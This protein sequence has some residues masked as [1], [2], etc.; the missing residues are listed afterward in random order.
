MH[1][2][3]SRV[4]KLW[5]VA[6]CVLAVSACDPADLVKRKVP[7]LVRDALTFGMQPGGGA[8]GADAEKP[9]LA[10]VSPKEN[11]AYAPGQEILFK[12]SGKLTGGKNPQQ[13]ELSWNLTPVSGEGRPQ[14]WQG[15]NTK[16][17]KLPVGRYKVE[18]TAK[19]E[20][21]PQKYGQQPTNQEL[22]ITASFA[23]AY[24][25]KG[26]VGLGA[27]GLDQAEVQ[28]VDMEKSTVAS[29]ATSGKNG[30]FELHF[31]SHGSFKIEPRKDGYSFSPIYRRVKF[32]GE[33]L[34]LQFTAAKAAFRNMRITVAKDSDEKPASL[35]PNDEAYL[36]LEVVSEVPVVSLEASLLN[37][38][39]EGE[40]TVIG[41][42]TDLNPTPSAADPNA[43]KCV[44]IKI[45]ISWKQHHLKE[46]LRLRVTAQDQA[47]GH[48]AAEAPD[49]VVVD[50]GVCMTAKTA[51]ALEL[52][53]K[54]NLE[55]ALSEFSGSL[56]LE[57]NLF[58]TDE[59]QSAAAKSSLNAGLVA[60]ELV[61][62]SP[63]DNPKVPGYVGKALNLF[64]DVVKL[65]PRDA[66]AL[67]LRGLARQLR[68]DYV[69]ALADYD[70]VMKI[71]PRMAIA[72]KL[73][74]LALA[75]SGRPGSVEDAIDSFTEALTL[76][77]GDT[78]V[79]NARKA[80]LKRAL[81]QESGQED[82]TKPPT[83]PSVGDFIN[84]R[85]F[86]RK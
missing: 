41:E 76:E 66:Q 56:D 78:H 80:S 33:P 20:Q 53:N 72:H 11:Q 51:K 31:P 1:D 5:C 6:V 62:K 29:K 77:K 7:P 17:K 24:A 82:G 9:T 40:P 32:T 38:S 67:L 42:A 49:P 57:K 16:K 10:I 60:L 86:V 74:G 64:T 3:L 48:F 73:K 34:N 35:C 39:E 28:V 27:G 2:I 18:L 22:K 43:P 46:S 69:T 84:P 47:D 54:G 23:V 59:I 79:R 52:Y 85:E 55:S 65:S 4:I 68:G 19:W 13:G 58:A 44:A 36:K 30:E 26:R 75:L 12:T 81:I 45:P 21:P 61:L 50:L 70:A 15:D 63:A 83:M 37:P 8:S 14:N 25:A 71:S